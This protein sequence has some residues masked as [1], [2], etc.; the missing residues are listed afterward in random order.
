MKAI[1][2]FFLLSVI[3]CSQ[4]VIAQ[5]SQDANTEESAADLA[6]KLANPISSLI[7][8]PFQNKIE[9]ISAFVLHAFARLCP[10]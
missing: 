6:K 9:L 8:L 10:E 2:L 4:L 5:D 1:K 3:F 7:S